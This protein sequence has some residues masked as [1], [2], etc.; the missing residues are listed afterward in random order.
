M[1]RP[2]EDAEEVIAER[3]GDLRDW[4]AAH[5]TR[6]TG[7]WLVTWKAADPDRHIPWSDIVDEL[8]CVGW[9]DSLPRKR[10]DATTML[11]IAPREP[12][13]NW[14]R[15]N[16]DKI[17]RLEAEG[18]MTAPGRAA[19]EAAKADGSWSA[20][21]E[22]EALMIPDDLQ[23]AFD[24]APGAED[25]WHAFPRTVKRG[26]LEQLLNARRPATRAARIDTIVTDSAA[27][28]RPFQWR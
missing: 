4:L 5:H 1:A 15:I 7:V 25:A 2:R 13:S 6:G 3:I 18:R 27:G 9:I 12:G 22:V 24:A 26:A 8:L 19:V 16:K 23:A 17:A 20:L 10:D 28:R 14:S 11:W 21:D